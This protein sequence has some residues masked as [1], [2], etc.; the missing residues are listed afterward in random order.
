MQ[1][2]LVLGILTCDI[3]MLGVSRAPAPGSA[4]PV[5]R[6]TMQCGG[7][8]ANCAMDIAKLG[9]P[10]TLCGR[11]GSD[12]F[13]DVVEKALSAYPLLD[14]RVVR[15]PDPRYNTTTSILSIHPSGERGIYTSLGSTFRFCRADLPEDVL[16]RAD[17]IFISGALLLNGFEPRAEADFLRDMQARGK[18]TCMDTCYDTEEVWLPKILP[19]LP[20]LDLFMPSY[21][22]AVKLTGRKDLDAI[23]D[24]LLAMG[25]RSLVIKVGSKG[26]YLCPHD[27]PRALIPAYR[28]KTCVDTTGAGD[29]F[30]AGLL[31]GLATGRSLE[32]AVRLGNMVGASCVTQIGGQAGLLSLEETLSLLGRCPTVPCTID[33]LKGGAIS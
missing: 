2:I 16:N 32:D 31:C 7:T 10:V 11:I 19:A 17:L 27:G 29:S 4:V 26:A 23:A 33:D 8:A 6:V 1:N 18:F 24:S 21:N 28:Y 9:L 15:D 22:E 13:G 30:C 20:Y 5:D 14:N 3:S 12:S 25:V